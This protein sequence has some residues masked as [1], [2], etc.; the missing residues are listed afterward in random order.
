MHKIS[1]II[2]VYNV[3]QFLPQCLESVRN[4][5]YQNL[6][7]ILVN[8]G[9]TDSC[10]QI[11]EDYAAKDE[12][13]KVIHKRNG[14]LSDAR[15]E[16]L[17]VATGDFISYI[18]SDDVVSANFCKQL[19][20]TLLENKAD[21]VE[22]GF[23]TFLR[24]RD[25]EKFSSTTQEKTEIFETESALELLMKEYFKQ[26]VW[27]KLY[28]REVVSDLKFP[29]GKINE[30]EFWTYKVFGNSTTVVRI[31]KELY[32]YRQ[33]ENS[34]MGKKYSI[35]RLDGLQALNDRIF[36]MKENFPI[37]ENLA[38][39]VFCF[40]SFAH[41]QKI[42]EQPTVDLHKI[43]RNE[44][45]DSVRKYNKFPLYKN[46]DMKTIFWFQLFMWAPNIY[47]KCRKYND[48]RVAYLKQKKG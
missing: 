10:P 31:S 14:G 35:K 22:C 15:N 25:L 8:D 36:Y 21:V 47:V 7:V 34:I 9:S 19:L 11:C 12:R 30:D 28:R 32:F 39:K 41:Y 27:N 13:I 38:I 37:L 18:D 45:I 42:C 23:L 48:H 2:P 43:F 16:G 6:E 1:I 44:I 17:K 33:Q 4:Q 20:K 29:I 24:D 40:G 46:W 26:V 5:T 3:E